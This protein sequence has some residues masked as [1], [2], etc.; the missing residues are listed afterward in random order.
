MAAKGR[1]NLKKVLAACGF[2]APNIIGV[3]MFTIFP[4]AFSLVMAFTNWDLRRH[5]RFRDEPLEFVGLSNFIRLVTE[6]DFLK[7]L[8]NT[9]FLMMAIPFSVAGALVAAMLLSRDTRGGSM[10][11]GL[12]L[13]A[14]GVLVA[15]ILLL[16]VLGMGATSMLILLT[17][18]LCGVI[19]LGMTGGVT[20]YRTLF[21]T[22]H[23][24]MGVPTFLLWK[25]MYNPENGP[26]NS[27]LRPM[28]DRL[29]GVVEAVPAVWVQAGLWVCFG[30]MIGLLLVGLSKI[31]RQ[32]RDGELGSGAAVIPVLFVLIPLAVAMR[33][34]ATMDLL[35]WPA[36]AALALALIWQGSKAARLGRDFVSAP[37]EGVGGALVLSL[38]IMVGQFVLLGLAPVLYNLPDM[39][40]G[41]A[42][43]TDRPGLEPPLWIYDYHWAKPSLMLMGLWGAIGSNNMLLYLA[44][45]TNI[46]QDLYEAAD[47]D[48]AS[49]FQKFWNVTWPQLAP[50]TFFI[51][52]M[53]TIHGLQG[54][55]EAAR[56][57]TNGGPAGATTTLS[58]FIYI[59]GFRTGRL[60]FSAAVAWALFV[61]IFLLTLF[62]WKFGNK[63]VNE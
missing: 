22:P 59:E 10:R 3:L 25:K 31:R 38:A 5:N 46:P 45:L 35:F 53:A 47:I 55:F 19:V 54:G 20:A 43:A 28:L 60:S 39:V 9:L 16:T 12:A 57:M 61:M 1:N 62:N 50:T 21:Y 52:V 56:T 36:V 40:A 41:A 15:S 27:A 4:V 26:I 37:M 11:M 49:R 24:V 29:G 30:L 23:F 51:A 44:A 33:W 14:S 8:G 63:Y 42:G 13:L 17:G 32:W 48:G 6:D 18:V 2:L 34:R 58:Y 7:Y